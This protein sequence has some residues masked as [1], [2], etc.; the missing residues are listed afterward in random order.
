M[1]VDDECD[2]RELL[3]AMLE[4][5][6]ATVIAAASVAEALA[7]LVD[8][9]NGKLPDVLLSD[10]GMP[11]EDGFDLIRRVRALAPQDG[12]TIPAIALTAYATTQ[13]R[14]RVLEAGFDRHLAKPIEPAT[15]AS[16]VA[17]VAR[18]V[19]KA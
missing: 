6:G 15:L 18:R 3:V 2:A 8:A 13:D 7:A 10:L 11:G 19:A 12:G 5:R 9:S 14:A 4:K 16:A 17:R 1:I